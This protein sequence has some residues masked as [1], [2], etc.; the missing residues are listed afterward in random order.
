MMS[1]TD[2]GVVYRKE[3][4]DEPSC[5][6][7]NNEFCHNRQDYSW[8][9]YSGGKYCHHFWN[10]NLYRLK[11]KTDGTPYADK[12]LASS[13]EVSSISGYNPNPSGLATAQ[14]APINRAGRGEY[15]S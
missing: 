14:T 11:T 7:V 9:L 10:E 6:G 4:I 3:E 1:R 2:R 13:E 15:P 5:S 8:G 12:S